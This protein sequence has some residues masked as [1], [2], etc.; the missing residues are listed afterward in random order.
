MENTDRMLE[1]KECPSEL[2]MIIN[3]L[4][5]LQEISLNIKDLK[6]KI[7]STSDP[8]A[9]KLLT[10][11]LKDSLNIQKN[12]TKEL[13]KLTGGKAPDCRILTKPII[14]DISLA[15]YDNYTPPSYEE[16]A[17]CQIDI[18]NNFQEIQTE[19]NDIKQCILQSITHLQTN[20][21]SPDPNAP[22]LTQFL[23]KTIDQ[24]IKELA[25]FNNNI[26]ISEDL[27]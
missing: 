22:C 16:F 5:L 17:L 21:N 3:R 7:E 4:I 13:E 20:I 15:G 8:S 1:H 18:T 10:V 27:N 12:I 6:A 25:E 26:T 2:S 19:I 23:L 11:E 9:K 24:Q 14:P